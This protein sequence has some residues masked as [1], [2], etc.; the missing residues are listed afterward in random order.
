V[1]N[2]NDTLT[3]GELQSNNSDFYG[4]AL[5]NVSVVVPEPATFTLLLLPLGAVAL[6]KV[7]KSRVA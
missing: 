1:A 5:D 2:G 6:R 3:F 4:L 7:R